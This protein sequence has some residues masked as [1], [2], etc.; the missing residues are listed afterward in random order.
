MSEIET[1]RLLLRNW[2]EADRGLFHEIN[3]D[4]EVMT[5][6]PFRRSRAE[7]DPVLDLLREEISGFGFGFAAI[8]VK[9][10]G[11]CAGFAG[12]R[13]TRL[14]PHLPDGT[15]EIGWRLARRHWGKGYASE[16]ARAW[17]RHGF[18]ALRLAEIVSFA[19]HDNHRSTAVMQ[20]IGMS[21]DPSRDFDHPG[22]PDA[23]R[24]LQRHVVYALKAEQ[25]LRLQN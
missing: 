16:A 22:V 21:R 15:V 12:I 23:F 2:R 1:G 11:E 6:F 19:V 18:E 10:S 20:R 13:H 14:E 25:W 4:E 7:S 24:H 9:A 5:F 8:E 17:L 3:S